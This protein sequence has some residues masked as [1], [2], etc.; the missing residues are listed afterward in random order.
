MIRILFIFS[1][2][3][4]L[5]ACSNFTDK[6]VTNFSSITNESNQKLILSGKDNFSAELTSKDNWETAILKDKSNLKEYKL[7]R[8]ISG[9]GIKLSNTEGV[10]IQF[11]KNYGFFN[12]TKN[13]EIDFE[14]INSNE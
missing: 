11:K 3:F 4:I 1:T 6:T 8:V 10:S 9:D 12:P 14:I 7:K 13:K 2:I 5:G